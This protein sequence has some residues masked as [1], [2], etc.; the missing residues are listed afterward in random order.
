MIKA[1]KNQESR[2]SQGDVYKNVEYVEHI[3]EY[4]G[5]VEISKIIFPYIIVLT[6]DCDLAQDFEFRLEDSKSEDK[7]ILSVLVAP[8]YNAEQVYLGE[9]LKEI[10]QSMATINKTKTPGDLLRQNKNPRYH[11]LLFPDDIDVVSSVIDFKHYF[12][13][14]VECLNKIKKTNFVCKVSVLY[15]EDTSQRF[16]SFLSR[17]GLP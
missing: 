17:I 4:D 13:V 3:A 12:S 8:I 15:R 14:N 9:H 5:I 11:Y 1:D 10:G 7:L 16:A 2:I 6:Q